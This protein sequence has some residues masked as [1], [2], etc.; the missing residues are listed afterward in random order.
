MSATFESRDMIMACAPNRNWKWDQA[1]HLF[2]DSDA[3]LHAFAR[4]LGLRREWFQDGAGRN[5]MHH[6]DLTVGMRAK[7]VRMGAVEIGWRDVGEYN[8][9]RWKQPG[10]TMTE[11]LRSRAG[12]G[13]AA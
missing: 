12:E 6:Y 5:R 9:K 10:L 1:C 3:E 8:E 2:A 7:A 13:G 11:F 4:S